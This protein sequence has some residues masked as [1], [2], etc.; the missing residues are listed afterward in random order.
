ML[1]PHGVICV[2]ENLSSDGFIVD[3]QDSSLTRSDLHFKQIFQRAGCTL[4]L[5]RQQQNFPK[6]LFKVKMC[7]GLSCRPLLPAVDV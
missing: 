2:K 5:E 6:E 7:G 4:L 1:K 3:R